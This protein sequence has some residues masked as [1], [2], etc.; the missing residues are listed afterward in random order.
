MTWVWGTCEPIDCCFAAVGG[1][2]R[3][4]E[5]ASPLPAEDHAGWIKQLVNAQLTGSLLRARNERGYMC[6]VTQD[7]HVFVLV[8]V[9][10][11][12]NKHKEVECDPGGICMSPDLPHHQSLCPPALTQTVFHCLCP[13]VSSSRTWRNWLASAQGWIFLT[14]AASVEKNPTRILTDTRSNVKRKRNW[15]FFEMKTASGLFCLIELLL[16]LTCL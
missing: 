12:A 3:S 6:R 4:V 10:P 9:H 5:L 13:S 11:H 16:L 7:A 8:H 14:M 15:A 2:W 1:T